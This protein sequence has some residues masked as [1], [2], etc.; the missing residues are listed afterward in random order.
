MS[1][2]NIR[3]LP[4]PTAEAMELLGETKIADV[5]GTYADCLDERD[6]F[7]HELLGMEVDLVAHSEHRRELFKAWRRAEHRL[8]LYRLLLN[9]LDP[10]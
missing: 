10:K 9:E 5:L 6:R 3:V 1:S 7:F 2:A 4:N 8:W